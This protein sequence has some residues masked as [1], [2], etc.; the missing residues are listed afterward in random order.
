MFDRSNVSQSHYT[1]QNH[2]PTKT[3]CLLQ[4]SGQHQRNWIV[5]FPVNH[6]S[7]LLMCVTIAFQVE[8]GVSI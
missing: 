2:N 5:F 7:M 8:S 1:I 4:T 6:I 3:L